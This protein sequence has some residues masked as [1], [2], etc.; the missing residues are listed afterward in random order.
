MAVKSYFF[1]SVNGDRKYSASDIGRYL[2][3]IVSSGVYADSSTSLQVLAGDG[4]QIQVQPGRAMLDYHGMENDAPLPLTLAAGGTQDRYDAIMAVL[5]VN[6]RLCDIV[7]RE[8]TPAANATVPTVQRTDLVKEYM[9]AA[10]HIPKY[11]KALSQENITDTRPDNAVCGWVH[12]II[13]QVDTRTLHAQY[14][15]AYAAKMAELDLYIADKKAEIDSRLESIDSAIN[16]ENVV[17]VPIPTASN[18]GQVPTVNRSGTRYTLAYPGVR[19]K[20]L[21]DGKLTLSDYGADDAGL[22]LFEGG[23]NVIAKT[24]ANTFVKIGTWTHGALCHISYSTMLAT[25]G[26]IVGRVT[27]LIDLASGKTYTETV[28][29]DSEG[30]E[31]YW[32]HTA[33]SRF[34][35]SVNNTAPDLSGNVNA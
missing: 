23:G 19:T 33:K 7:V 3:G 22:Y 18:A 31:T 5:D 14:E 26:Q 8:G 1:D 25:D 34:V 32:A 30:V 12:G 29:W 35:S 21:D 9:L 15:A 27:T 16:G 4:M 10:V 28:K 24:A 17:G 13:D 2:H 11:A 20:R 6:N